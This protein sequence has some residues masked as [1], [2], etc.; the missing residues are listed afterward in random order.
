M[1]LNKLAYFEI[2]NYQ[3]NKQMK[4]RLIIILVSLSIN[5]MICQTLVHICV[6][7]DA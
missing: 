1:D 4:L 7:A 5:A 2:I 6:S 3:G